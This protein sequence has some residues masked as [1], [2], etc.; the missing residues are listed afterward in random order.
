MSFIGLIV[1][2]IVLGFILYIVKLLPID[3]TIKKIIYAVVIL[4]ALLWVLQGVGL[5]G[6]GPYLTVHTR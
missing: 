2:L 3:G 6:G 4:L 5:L 1:A